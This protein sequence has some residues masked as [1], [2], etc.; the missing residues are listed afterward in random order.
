MYISMEKILINE[1]N[2]NDYEIEEEIIRVKGL[3]INE[4]KEILLMYNG[5]TFQ[6]P[7]GH[8]KH[9]ESLEDTLKREIKEETGMYLEIENGP[10]LL[11]TEYYKNYLSTGIN[12]CNKIYYYLI[13]SNASP[14]YQEIELTALEQETEF[15]L[16]YV[17]IYEFDKFLEEATKNN[18]IQDVIALEMKNTLDIYLKTK[19][20]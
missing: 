2:L 4:D 3:I 10:F 7:G 17:S 11:I 6:F 14:N 20:R 9:N 15:K 13:E 8:V 16:I 1:E 18:L 12:R 19:R 5:N